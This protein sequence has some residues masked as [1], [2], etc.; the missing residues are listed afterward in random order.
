MEFSV[1]F[2]GGVVNGRWDLASEPKPRAIICDH[3]AEDRATLTRH[4]G[5]GT[6]PARKE[7]SP[8]IQ[9]VAARLRR[10]GDGRPRLVIHRDALVERDRMLD[11]ARKPVSTAEE[12]DSYVWDTEGNRKGGEVPL[13]RHDHGLDCIRY[14]VFWLDGGGHV[15]YRPTTAKA[16]TWVDEE[17]GVWGIGEM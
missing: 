6:T 16:T 8:G 5:I 9:A 2:D 7:V 10:A 11:A 17:P 3:D 15:E 1:R 13:K 12:F 4:L 14:V